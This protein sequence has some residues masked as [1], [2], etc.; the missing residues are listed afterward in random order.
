VFRFSGGVSSPR[1]IELCCI[2][3][4]MN[5]SRWLLQRLPDADCL[6]LL[7]Q[8]A[9]QKGIPEG[10]LR[11]AVDLS[12]EVVDDLLQALLFSGQMVAFQK[13]GKRWVRWQG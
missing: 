13:D 11:S 7:L 1:R 9:G 10:R 12:K 8:Q 2:P 3:T 5:F 4:R 6:V